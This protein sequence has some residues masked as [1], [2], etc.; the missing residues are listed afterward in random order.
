MKTHDIAKHLNNLARTQR[1]GPNVEL[2]DLDRLLSSTGLMK[3][4]GDI[5]LGLSTLVELSRIDKSQWLSLIEEL[6]FDIVLR[7]RDASRDVLDKLL[8]Y[9][10]ENDVARERLKAT[11][12]KRSKEGAPHLMKALSTL[13]QNDK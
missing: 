1:K 6:G 7:P 11:V 5:A 2:S 12:K 8:R 10:V 9:L 13:L 3:P 4:S